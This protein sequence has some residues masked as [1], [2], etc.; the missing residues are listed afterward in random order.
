MKTLLRS[1][2]LLAASTAFA[3]AAPEGWL[4]D[5]EAAKAKSAAD[6]EAEKA[7]KLAADEALKRR[8]DS[9]KAFDEARLR[10]VMDVAAQRKAADEA[11][12]ANELIVLGFLRRGMKVLDLKVYCDGAV[13]TADLDVGLVPKSTLDD[14][15][16]NGL[17][18]DADIATA[19][20]YSITPAS[21]L[22]EV[23]EDSYL[24][25]KL[26]TAGLANADVIKGY[27][28]VFENI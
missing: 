27:A 9:I 10:R 7:A 24:V 18:N 6:R 17:M 19:G 26:Q 4:T 15:A 21:I 25:G 14:A 2:L 1:A 28:L 16:I 5:W 23:T 11:K 22:T 20:V 13:A 12:A 3:L 8:E